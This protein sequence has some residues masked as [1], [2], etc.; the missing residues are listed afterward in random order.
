MQLTIN[1][2]SSNFSIKCLTPQLSITSVTTFE[3]KI[4]IFSYCLFLP[5]FLYGR[6]FHSFLFNFPICILSPT[7]KSTA[8][9]L[10]GLIIPSLISSG[11]TS[12]ECSVQFCVPLYKRD[13]DFPEWIQQRAMKIMKAL[14]QMC[15]E[16][17]EAN[18]T[19]QCREQKALLGSYQCV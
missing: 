4:T 2:L 14:K 16:C 3:T 19:V 8:S 6:V 5:S 17:G 13:M 18:R 15:Q 9:R 12:S 1:N 11:D 10:R 7:C